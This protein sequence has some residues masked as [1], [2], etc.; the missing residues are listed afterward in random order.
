MAVMFK[1]NVLQARQREVD[2]IYQ[3]FLKTGWTGEHLCVESG[4]YRGAVTRFTRDRKCSLH[5][6][7]Q[8]AITIS[9]YLAT[10]TDV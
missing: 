2:A 7:G 5:I 4:V 6:A 9:S 1:N 3:G 8:L 10:R